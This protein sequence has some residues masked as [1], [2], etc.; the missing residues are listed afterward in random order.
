MLKRLLL[1]ITLIITA[2]PLASCIALTAGGAAG[3][4]IAS[5]DRTIGTMIDDA[6]LTTKIN[7]KLLNHDKISS[8]D[9]NIDTRNKIVTLYGNVES[10]EDEN[11][12]IDI[13][14]STKGVEKVISKV[15]IDNIE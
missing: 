10:I 14:K 9:I 13:A 6:A 3:A 11:E 15:N 2:L 7:G 12:L 8:F 5:D 4:Y 1:T